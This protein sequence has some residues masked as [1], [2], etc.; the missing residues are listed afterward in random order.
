MTA[1][2]SLCSAIKAAR[3]EYLMILNYLIEYLNRTVFDKKIKKLTKANT[4]VFKN[5]LLDLQPYYHVGPDVVKLSTEFCM[6]S[7]NY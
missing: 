3:E 5:V 7:T 4:T 6:P 1:A 2:V